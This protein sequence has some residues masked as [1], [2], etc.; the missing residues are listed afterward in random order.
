[1]PAMKAFR[2]FWASIV[3]A[4]PSDAENDAGISRFSAWW[5]LPAIA[6]FL[7]IV[8]GFVSFL[9]YRRSASGMTEMLVEKG[10]S[11][12]NVFESAI[13]TGR[14]GNEGLVLQDLLE[15][16]AKGPDIEF[17]AITM[18][19]GMIMYYPDSE[20][21]GERLM[22][23]ERE[24]G[25][26]MMKELDPG[27]I[28]KSLHTRVDGRDVFLVYRE[29]TVGSAEWDDNVPKLAIFLGLEAS[30]FEITD[31]QNRLYVSMLAVATMLVVLCGLLAVSLAQRA[32]DSRQK[33]KHAE[34]EMHRLEEEMRRQEKLAAVG[35]MA[36]GVAHEIR[37]PLSSIKGYATYFQQKFE[38]GSEDRQAATV[39]VSEVDR[40]NR[41]ITDLLGLSR[42]DDVKPKP[43]RLDFI[44]DH[45]KKLVHPQAARNNVE[46]KVR[47]APNVPEIEGDAER[48]NQ[49]L[50]N[51]CLNAIQA[52]PD[53]GTLT[54]ALSGGKNRICIMVADTGS[55]IA[56]EHMSRI[57]D[58]Y[59][60]TRG[61]GTGLGL[62]MVHKIV[63]AH[64][65]KMDV[66]SKQAENGAGGETLFRIWLPVKFVEKDSRE[67]REESRTKRGKGRAE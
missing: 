6:L 15:E 56:P 45:I 36:A 43:V 35:T 13:R 27:E 24:L 53:G 23:G 37:N 65:G 20:R 44:L 52:M 5:V 51:L 41:V 9:I 32:A 12:I 49:A 48:L 7:A 3:D 55:G 16:M 4:G 47:M 61:R 26:E 66:T 8:I 2:E 50:L 59:F 14:K 22:I 39:M 28:E 25:P 34:G 38:E 33:Q 54:L 10:T 42:P 40:L 64:H 29:F 60:T 30:P 18:P 63:R 19:N 21:I 67:K 1:M 17:V 31:N 57:F 46:M 11:L 58:P 62:P